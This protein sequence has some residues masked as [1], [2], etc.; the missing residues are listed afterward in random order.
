MMLAASLATNDL[1]WFL[2]FYTFWSY[3]I[4]LFAIFFTVKAVKHWEYQWWA[5]VGM[6]LA[7]GIDLVCTPGYWILFGPGM[8]NYGWKGMDLFL[9]LHMTTLHS[10][11]LIGTLLNL[12]L[13]D[14]N[15]F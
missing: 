3:F 15:F 12:I 13:T 5:A 7:M 14:M 1:N 4:S 8:K 11:P 9:R 10:V 6:E 2:V